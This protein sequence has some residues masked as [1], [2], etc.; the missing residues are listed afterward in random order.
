LKVYFFS[1]KNNLKFLARNKPYFSIDLCAYLL[2][3]VTHDV[4]S[5]ALAAMSTG[6]RSTLSLGSQWKHLMVPI[7]EPTVMPEGPFK[8]SNQPGTGSLC[9]EMTE[10]LTQN[11]LNYF[12][13]R[14]RI[15]FALTDGRSENGHWHVDAVFGDERLRQHFA[16]G[17]GVWPVSQQPVTHIQAELSYPLSNNHE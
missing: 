6:M 15:V 3:A 7:R 14:S 17:V 11:V 12:L 5:I 2:L 4:T 9:V 8:L 13:L 1:L 10:G 16:V